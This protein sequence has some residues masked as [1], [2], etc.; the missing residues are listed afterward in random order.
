ML[1]IGAGMSD[2]DIADVTN[3]VRKSWGNDA[4]ATASAES[5][6]AACAASVDTLMNGERV[7]GCPAVAPARTG[8]A[9]RIGPQAAAA[10]QDS[11]AIT[12]A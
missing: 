5:V 3:Y 11:T 2:A 12:D 10:R 9:R 8:A 7:T 1:A 4:P 6:H